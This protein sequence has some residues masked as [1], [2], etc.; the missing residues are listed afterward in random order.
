MHPS[1]L[2]I[3]SKTAT[4]IIIIYY[5][6]KIVWNRPHIVSIAASLLFGR[7]VSQNDRYCLLHRGALDSIDDDVDDAS[8]GVGGTSCI[9]D[10]VVVDNSIVC[11]AA[12]MCQ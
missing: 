12:T 8:G 7:H 5:Y 1:N 2:A 11:I 10:P 3:T 9:H 4:T 6:P